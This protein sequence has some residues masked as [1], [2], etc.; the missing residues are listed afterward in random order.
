M[1]QLLE[2]AS[3]QGVSKRQ[4]ESEAQALHA[5]QGSVTALEAAQTQ[6]AQYLIVV[7]CPLFH[8]LYLGRLLACGGVHPA[9]AKGAEAHAADLAR[10]LE[11]SVAEAARLREAEHAALC[12]SQQLSDALLASH[13]HVKV[14]PQPLHFQD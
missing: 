6:V 4:A 2:D 14:H 3:E 8:D 10:R 13:Q 5:A 7:S 11:A 9:Q 12:R 1:L